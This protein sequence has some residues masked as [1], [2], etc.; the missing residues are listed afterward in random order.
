MSSTAKADMN[1]SGFF[2]SGGSFDSRVRKW[3][4][5]INEW[6]ARWETRLGRVRLS[7]S[8]RLTTPSDIAR[9]P[10]L[11]SSSIIASCLSP[12]SWIQR[13]PSSQVRRLRHP[14]PRDVKLM[15]PRVRVT[16]IVTMGTGTTTTTTTSRNA[17]RLAISVGPERSNAS[18]QRANR[19]VMAV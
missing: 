16:R 14:R 6:G 19:A 11:G 3:E 15:G 8:A 13:T 18:K 9:A 10:Q 4:F 17:N 1:G 7:S 5:V 2:V 12:L